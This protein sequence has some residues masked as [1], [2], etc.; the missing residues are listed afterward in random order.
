MMLRPQDEPSR[1]QS[2]ARMRRGQRGQRPCRH[3]GQKIV[4]RGGLTMHER[5]C[6]WRCRICPGECVAEYHE[7]SASIR[8]WLRERLRLK[9]EPMVVPKPHTPRA[10]AP[11]GTPS[12]P[13]G[14]HQPFE[15]TPDK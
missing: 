3:C 12:P 5:A 8:A 10:D 11:K 2:I 4:S 6:I 13:S 14:K 9:L 15:F 7:A 1:A